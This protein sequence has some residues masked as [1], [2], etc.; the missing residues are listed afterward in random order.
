MR[1]VII[2][3]LFISGSLLG[4]MLD[5]TAGQVFEEKPFFNQTFIAKNKIKSLKGTYST[6]AQLD[7]IR[8]SS[9]IYVYEFDDKGRL[10]REYKTAFK[11]TIVTNYKYNDADQLILKRQ[12]DQYGFHSYAY[13]YDDQGRI[14]EQEYR[15]D[16]NKGLDK[17][18]FELDETF[19]ITTETFSYLDF[20][21]STY[22]KVYYNNAGREYKTEFFYH[23]WDG[24]LV[25]QE[26]K[27]RNGSGNSKVRFAYDEKGRISAK[28]SEVNLTKNNTSRWEYEYDEFGNVL[29]LRYY[30]NGQWITEYQILYDKTTLFLTAII[31]R[32]HATNF[33]MILQFKEVFFYR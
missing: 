7:Y 23:T 21:D 5:N 9:D 29:A 3:I 28:Q 16:S 25:K 30:R 22:K 18:N 15:R 27:L 19:I 1:L 8:P 33:M 6:K 14:L 24:Q 11:D 32:D 31:T 10:S 12:S 4:Q 17:M 26:G 20:S 13:T 2:Y